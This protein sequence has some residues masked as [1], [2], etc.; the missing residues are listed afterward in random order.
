[1]ARIPYPQNLTAETREKLSRLGNLNV[2]RMMSHAEPVM[3]AYAKL[4]VAILRRSKLD[5]KLRE[6]AILK[7]GLLCESEYEWHQ[8]EP[9]ARA[10][11]VS[12]EAIGGLASGELDPLSEMEKLVAAFASETFLQK[13][14]SDETFKAISRHLSH[15]E[16]VELSLT[17]GYYIMT[18]GYLRTFDIEIEDGPALGHT[19]AQSSK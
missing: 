18:A 7:I 10:V 17:C 8:H 19:V 13:R 9:Y 12:E 4:G 14:V 6:I 5:P 15:E 2:T 16:L 11:G 1:M 3:D